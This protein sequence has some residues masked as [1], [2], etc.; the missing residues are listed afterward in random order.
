MS[1]DALVFPFEVAQD[2]KLAVEDLTDAETGESF[3][4]L[5]VQTVDDVGQH[6]IDIIDAKPAWSRLRAEV[7][8]EFLPDKIAAVCSDVSRFQ[9]ETEAIV[10]VTCGPTKFRRGMRLQASGPNKWKGG[11]ELARADVHATIEL[12]PSIVRIVDCRPVEG[13]GCFSGAILAQGPSVQI[14]ADKT[15]R[16]FDGSIEWRWENFA[17]STNSWRAARKDD[18]FHLEPGEIPIM[19]LNLR[20][21]HLKQ[22]LEHEGRSGPAAAMRDMTAALI[23]QAGWTQLLATALASIQE[24]EDQFRVAGDAWRHDLVRLGLEEMY[25]ELPAVERMKAAC[26]DWQRPEMVGQLISKLGAIAQNRSRVG[27]L[28]SNAIQQTDAGVDFEPSN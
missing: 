17:E 6:R 28:F 18:V 8:F 1:T 12:K 2:L 16:H 13:F 10:S 21:E 23:A 4:G 25:S 14:I 7:S 20:W 19:Y 5:R 22:T 15:A 3:T 27:K 26:E 11:I 24:E 9:A